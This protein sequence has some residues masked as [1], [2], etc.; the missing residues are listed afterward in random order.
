MLCHETFLDARKTYSFTHKVFQI[1]PN[2]IAC[3]FYFKTHLF[4]NIENSCTVLTWL[5]RRLTFQIRLLL[6]CT[7]WPSILFH[8]FPISF[9]LKHNTIT[10]YK[11][12]KFTS[13]KPNSSP[14]SSQK[15]FKSPPYYFKIPIH[16]FNLILTQNHLN[17]LKSNKIIFLEL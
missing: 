13:L 4:Q 6:L 9:P 2:H 1:K 16:H 5:L 11:T 10:R 17:H 3:P 12:P 7:K 14:I 8:M 15:I